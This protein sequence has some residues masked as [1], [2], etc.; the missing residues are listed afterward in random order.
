[1]TKLETKLQETQQRLNELQSQKKDKSQR[2]I[3]SPEQQKELEDFQK[4]EADARKQLKEVRKELN[5]DIDSLKNN[6]KWINI[7]AMPVLVSLF[8]IGLAV[9][10]SKKTGAK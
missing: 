9:V 2:F 4:Q 6:V 1:V 10:K 3:L 5:K 8:G 7:M